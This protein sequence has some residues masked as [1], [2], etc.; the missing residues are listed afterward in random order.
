MLDPAIIEETIRLFES[1][2]YVPHRVAGELRAKFGLSVRN[3]YKYVRKALARLEEADKTSRAQ[4]FLIVDRALERQLDRLLADPVVNH[5]AVN[6]VLAMRLKLYGFDKNETKIVDN[7][8]HVRMLPL[9][10]KRKLLGELLRKA[11]ATMRD[12]GRIVLA[13]S[14]E[15]KEA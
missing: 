1:G 13:G 11:G 2:E 3:G 6:Q 9:E 10:A 12:D 4:R 5:S 7:S 14:E 8:T 15:S